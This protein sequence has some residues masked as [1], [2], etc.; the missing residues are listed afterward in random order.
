MI[1]DL[2]ILSITF[3]LSVVSFFSFRF[4]LVPYLTNTGRISMYR[5]NGIVFH[6]Y[7]LR[8]SFVVSNWAIDQILLGTKNFFNYVSILF[9]FKI[10]CYSRYHIMYMP[11][12]NKE[13]ISGLACNKRNI[14]LRITFKMFTS[15]R[16]TPQ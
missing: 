8:S 11:W 9:V 3:R 15:S 4:F 1:L 14:L 7:L 6:S 13:R 16:Y 12:R 2:A 5:E 10:K